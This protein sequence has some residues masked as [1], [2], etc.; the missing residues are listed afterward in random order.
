M[1]GNNSCGSH[2]V[3][4]GTT[5]DNVRELDVLRRRRRL[6]GS[7]GPGGAAP[8]GLRELAERAT[9]RRCAT[10]FPDLPRRI[11]G[12][13]LDALLPENGADVARALLRHRGHAGHVL[14]EAM[15]R[16]VEAPARAGAGRARLPR[17]ERRGGRRG[18]PAAVR[19]ADR[20]GHGRRTWCARGARREPLRRCRRRRWLFV[21]TGGDDRRRHARV[22]TRSCGAG[23]RQ[24]RRVVVTTRRGSGRCG[25]SARTRAGTAT[26]MPG[27]R[28]GLARLGGLRG[29]ARPARR[30]PAG[31]RALLADHGL[32]GTP[33]GH[34]G[35]GC[36]HVRIDFDLLTARGRRPLP[37]LL[38]GGRPTWSSRTAARCPGEHGD[39]QARAELL[40]R[41]VRRRD[42]RRVRA[43]QG[44]LGP[45]RPA[46]PRHA[47]PPA[48]RWTRTCGFAVLPPGARSTWRSATR[49]T[50]ATSR[51]RC[52][53]AWASASAVRHGAGGGV[54]CPPL[55]GDGR[56]GALHARAGPAAARD[57]RAAR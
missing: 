28:R 9:W 30:L 52:A 17:R 56:G 41:D 55:P 45:G 5:A 51:R 2:S 21:E 23:G 20:R 47:R 32:R 40:P 25:G 1:I 24:R 35:D 26:R 19:A 3:A 12:Y 22:R 53:G 37:P 4:W 16:L 15:V 27:R 43:S 34:F 57:A 38:G 13:A 49:R 29:A 54:M 18:R 14:T 48:T 6:D 11:S 33:Y 36:I 8:D 7:A 50:A 39:G 44:P 31:L 42:G 46:E 10:G